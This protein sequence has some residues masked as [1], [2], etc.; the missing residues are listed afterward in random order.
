MIHDLGLRWA[1][2]VLFALCVVAFTVAVARDH[3]S[4][5]GVV[6]QALH[7]V[8]AV[9]MGVM[10]WPGGAALPTTGP[11][12]FFLAA[13]VWF[14]VL[15]LAPAGSGHRVSNAY[16]SLMMLAMAWMYAVMNGHLL[17][18][19]HGGSMPGMSHVPRMRAPGMDMPGMHTA[20]AQGGGATWTTAVNWVLTL[21]FTA[22]TL[23]WVY[24]YFTAGQR[25]STG[26]A[27]QRAGIA[28]QAM[29]A[30]GMAI[31]FGVML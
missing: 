2:T 16:H 8:M 4:W 29:M 18:G 28:G 31:M 14:T 19:R 21:G 17:P 27:D 25:D 7:I 20:S 11:T 15:G 6:G 13:A 22:A 5:V 12:A 1:V 23:V 30:A 10:V 26:C 3:R 9:A 24:R